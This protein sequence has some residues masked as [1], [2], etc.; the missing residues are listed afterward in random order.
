ML[1]N[2]IIL[3]ILIILALSGFSYFVKI[4]F[5]DNSNST[6]ISQHTNSQGK[7]SNKRKENWK[8]LQGKGDAVPGAGENILDDRY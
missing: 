1:N 8:K 5:F 3:I 2:K 4:E 7:D 6:A